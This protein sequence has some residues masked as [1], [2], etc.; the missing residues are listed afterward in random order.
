[1]KL[2]QR[3]VIEVIRLQRMKKRL[4]NKQRLLAQRAEHPVLTREDGRSC[5]SMRSR[6]SGIHAHQGSMP[7]RP[8]R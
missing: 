4:A 6:H 1:M 7:S 5:A 3:Q 8:T 2:S